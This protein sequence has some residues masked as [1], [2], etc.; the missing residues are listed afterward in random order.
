[1]L[2]NAGDE[3]TSGEAGHATARAPTAAGQSDPR[4]DP[5]TAIGA[6]PTAAGDASEPAPVAIL[7]SA[8]VPVGGEARISQAPGLVT[9]AAVT[10]VGGDSKAAL[11]AQA[12][13]LKKMEAPPADDASQLQR[14]DPPADAILAVATAAPGPGAEQAGNTNDAPD[15]SDAR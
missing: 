12:V 8:S 7:A 15:H 5:A 13:L 11:A 6:S 14:I 1:M 4:G 9:T 3:T 2:P 10:Y